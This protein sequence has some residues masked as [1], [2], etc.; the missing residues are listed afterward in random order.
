M[1]CL[2]TGAYGFIGRE[3]VAALQRENVSV[4]AAGR[5]LALGRRILPG[6]EWIACDFN[7]DI[8]VAQWLPRLNGVDAVVNCVGALQGSARDDADRASMPTPRSRCSRPAPRR[9]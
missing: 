6:V 3:V 2:V 9:A 5:D 8:E 4:I 7:R 1:R